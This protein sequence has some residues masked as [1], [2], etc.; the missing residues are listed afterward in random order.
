MDVHPEKVGGRIREARKVRNLSEEELARLLNTTQSV[1]SLMETGKKPTLAVGELL[2]Y[3]KFLGVS[4]ADLLGEEF[5]ELAVGKSSDPALVPG[6]SQ[7]ERRKVGAAARF[8]RMQGPDTWRKWV[9]RPLLASTGSVAASCPG[10]QPESGAEDNRLIEKSLRVDSWQ[11]PRLGEPLGSKADDCDG[12]TQ[13]RS[14]PAG[15]RP[16]A[17]PKTGVVAK[18]I[19]RWNA[20]MNALKEWWGK[21]RLERYGCLASAFGFM[22]GVYMTHPAMPDVL[23]DAGVAVAAIFAVLLLGRLRT[24]A[25]RAAFRSPSP[26]ASTP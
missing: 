14:W 15:D 23:D 9:R 5:R 7:P 3:C 18:V 22:A 6:T 26:V 10:N 11:P 20:L 8:A 19:N 13:K 17:R 12:T 4:L 21:T 16:P 25:E 1:I 24:L 2:D